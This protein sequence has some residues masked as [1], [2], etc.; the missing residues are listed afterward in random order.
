MIVNSTSIATAVEAM[1]NDILRLETEILP[2][3]VPTPSPEPVP[4]SDDRVV[5]GLLAIPGTADLS[6][7]AGFIAD[8]L[9]WVVTTPVFSLGGDDSLVSRLRGVLSSVTGE[10]AGDLQVALSQWIASEL[11]PILS[12]ANVDRSE[13]AAVDVNNPSGAELSIFKADAGRASNGA[14]AATGIVVALNLAAAAADGGTQLFSLGQIQGFQQLVQNL[15]WA[16]GLS[17]IGGLSFRPQ[18][19][20]SFGPLLERHWNERSQAQIPGQGD[21]MRFLVREVFEPQR[22]QELRS[23]DDLSQLYPFM[24]QRGFSDFWT[25]SFWA[26]HWNLLSVTQLNEAVH[27]GTIGQD[28]WRRQVRLNDVVP[29]GVPWLEDI[30]YSPFTRVDVRRMENLGILDDREL[31][32]AYADIGYFAPKSQAE[33]GRWK[34]VFVPAEQFD[35]T[36]HKAQANVLFAKLFNALPSLRRRI[37]N[38]FIKPGAVE[39]ELL[40]LGL[41]PETAKR[42]TETLV[43]AED[44]GAAEATRTLTTAQ[45]VRGAKA[46]LISFN[47]GRFLLQQIGW[48]EVRA[49]FMLRLRMGED[50]SVSDTELGTRL[51]S[52]IA[53][54]DLPL[55]ESF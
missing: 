50:D 35:A 14:V 24:R 7:I 23:T 6:G 52:K 16:L 30:I 1:R 5:P 34:A 19:A 54:I 15:I 20:A 11:D 41:I 4:V 3:P 53:D 25:D 39:G 38:G 2:V 17:D 33:D 42:M 28:E 12:L 9:K 47:Q 26:A 8:S 36:T 45:I 21:L 46:G 49:E 55:S 37:S 51:V 27:R 40:A 29:E 32:Q 13:G 31:L 22:R 18:I 43:D 10:T 44:L 48:D